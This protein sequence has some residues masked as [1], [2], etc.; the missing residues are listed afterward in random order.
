MVF[1]A[2]HSSTNNLHVL[3]GSYWFDNIGFFLRENLLLCASYLPLGVPNGRVHLRAS[4]AIAE[5]MSGGGSEA[6]P[7][8]LSEGEIIAGGIYIAMPASEVM[9]E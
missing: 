1:V 5:P 4:A 7:G 3:L 6:L 2:L 9:R 8:T